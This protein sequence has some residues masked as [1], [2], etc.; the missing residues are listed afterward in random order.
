MKLGFQSKA[1]TPP[2][3]LNLFKPVIH[4]RT[5]LT[6]ERWD[7]V[8]DVTQ[9]AAGIAYRSDR[10]LYG[11]SE[12]WAFPIWVRKILSNGV[13]L[14]GDCE[15]VAMWMRR[16]LGKLG[17]P[18]GSLRLAYCRKPEAHIVLV[19]QTNQGDFSLSKGR[20]TPWE[21]ERWRWVSLEGYPWWNIILPG[22]EV[23]HG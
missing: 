1:L 16:E 4:K 13:I 15:D 18:R 10:E 17:W 22:R 5:K 23:E 20:V 7:Q 19:A 8:V 9:R 2:G 11:K 12:H 14:A 3:W 6:D 21:L